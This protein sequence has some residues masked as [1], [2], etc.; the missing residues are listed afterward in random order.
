MQLS[1]QSLSSAGLV[2]P[3]NEDCVGFWQPSDAQERQ[4]RGSIAV[5]ADG[6]GGHGD[7]RLASSTA[8]E[9]VLKKFR[10]ADPAAAPRQLLREI[11]DGVNLAL[12]DEGM[13]SGTRLITTLTVCIFRGKDLSVAHVGDTRVYLV[14]QEAITR[15][16]H[17][18]SNSGLQIRLRLM[19][20]L[21]GKASTSRSALTRSVGAEPVVRPDFKEIELHVRDRVVQCTDGLYCFI[22]D[23]EICEG[24]DRL[25]M[26]EICP[27]LVALAERRKTDDN[28]SVQVIRV[29]RISEPQATRTLSFLPALKSHEA[30]TGEIQPGQI[31]DNR[32]KIERVVNRSGMASI[33]KAVDLTTNQAVAIKIP[34]LQYES[35]AAFFSRFQREAEIGKKLNH[36]NILKFYDVPEQS[37]PYI[38]TEFLEGRTLNEILNEVK[39][40]PV[41]DA[42]QIASQICDALQHMHENG[43]VHRDLKPHN[44]M[45]CE[46]GR[47]CIIDFGIAKSA[48]SRR[49]TFVG[50]SP[51]M[52]TPDYMA[53]EQVKGRRGDARTDIYALGAMLYEMTTGTMPFEGPNPFVVMNARVSGDPVAPRKRNPDIPAEVEEIILHAMDRDPRHRFES[54]ARMK[55]ELDDPGKVRLT[56]RHHHLK[57]PKLWNTRWRGM[58]LAV[59]SALIPIAVLLIA[60]AFARCHPSHH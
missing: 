30:V 33:C 48:E 51:P 37:R 8:V 39:P 56:G 28:L 54:A 34:H 10:E 2:R 60:L 11:F 29:D 19:S 27:Y 17:D 6:V 5:M 23:G 42:V 50:F 26:D 32:F 24:V 52:G 47:L 4:H 3:R 44:V 21:E 38:A 25:N 31:L 41:G 12:Y 18:H 59:L 35:D 45:I 16:T 46:D 57:M 14:R 7:G 55:A 9:F 43:I 22:D 36:P 40:L 58:R 49:I 15:L 1:V 13:K 20:E 53:P